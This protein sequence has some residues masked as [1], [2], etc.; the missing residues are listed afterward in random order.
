[1]SRYTL[2]L[3]CPILIYLKADSLKTFTHDLPPC[4]DA[5]KGE[6]SS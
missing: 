4:V 5:L 2:N 1:M 6:N 3:V